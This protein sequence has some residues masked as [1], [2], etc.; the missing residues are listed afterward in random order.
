MYMIS[1][2]DF[3]STRRSRS[4]LIKSKNRIVLILLTDPDD[5]LILT[6]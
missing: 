5:L 2:D 6:V 3:P 1:H 4:T